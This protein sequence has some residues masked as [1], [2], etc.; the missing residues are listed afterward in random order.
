MFNLLE[1]R[2]FVLLLDSPSVL[3]DPSDFTDSF[4]PLPLQS[5]PTCNLVFTTSKGVVRRVT[6]RDPV[7]ADKVLVESVAS[8]RDI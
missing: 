1:V 3:C 6:S 7:A 2:V 8:C 5:L 4:I